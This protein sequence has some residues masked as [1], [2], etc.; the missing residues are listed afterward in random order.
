MIVCCSKYTGICVRKIYI[1][2]VRK[3]CPRIDL[4]NEKQINVVFKCEW[5]HKQRYTCNTIFAFSYLV[6]R[7]WLSV[8][9]VCIIL[10]S[11][12]VS[13]MYQLSFYMLDTHE[14]KLCLPHMK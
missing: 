13:M 2:N 4:L 6:Y 11:F 10:F 12:F 3:G 9:Y 7:T 14:N 8:E 1:D 5:F